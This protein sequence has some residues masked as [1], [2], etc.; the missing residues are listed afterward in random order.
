M[1]KLYEFSIPGDILTVYDD[2]VSFK[3]KG[4]IGFFTK[5]IQGERKIYY[6]QIASIQ[7]KNASSLLS[8]FIEFYL[9][10]HH[11]SKQG[12]GMLSG[13]QNENRFYFYK[14]HQS[15]MSK[16]YEYIQDKVKLAHST[17]VETKANDNSSADELRKFKQLL[18]EGIIT[19]E[20][21]QSKKKEILGF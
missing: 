21:F 3:H 6:K 1:E 13:T 10:G 7:Y 19:D 12:G 9:D 2:C 5:G 8:G 15:D 20:E 16:A 18:D 11:G 17:I 14:K 4:A